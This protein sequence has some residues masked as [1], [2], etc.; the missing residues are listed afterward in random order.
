MFRHDM[1][2]DRSAPLFRRTGE[3]R[4]RLTGRCSRQ[5][6][7]HRGAKL[8]GRFLLAV[9]RCDPSNAANSAESLPRQAGVLHRATAFVV[10]DTANH[11][12]RR[13]SL[14]QRNLGQRPSSRAKST[15]EKGGA[16]SPWC[17]TPG[18]CTQNKTCVA[19]EKP[20]TIRRARFRRPARGGETSGRLI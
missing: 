14:M 20:T 5:A 16:K 17:K 11:E 13:N 18:H 2:I 15:N 12:C 6:A 10:C 1:Q 7:A 4:N 19:K 3:G 9:R 8:A